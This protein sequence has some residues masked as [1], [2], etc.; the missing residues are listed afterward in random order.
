MFFQKVT[1]IQDSPF[2]GPTC[3]IFELTHLTLPKYYHPSFLRKPANKLFIFSAPDTTLEIGRHIDGGHTL[4]KLIT[5]IM[6]KKY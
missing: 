5:R 6:P 4:P 2:I 3:P 1:V